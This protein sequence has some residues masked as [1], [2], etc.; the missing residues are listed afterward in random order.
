MEV[1][2]EVLPGHPLHQ[3]Q[4]TVVDHNNSYFPFIDYYIQYSLLKMSIT[5]YIEADGKL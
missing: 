2:A 4:A 1:E 5:L 3:P